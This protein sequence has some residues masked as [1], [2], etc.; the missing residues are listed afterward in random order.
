MVKNNIFDWLLTDVQPHIGL[1]QLKNTAQDY[2][3]QN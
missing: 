3:K 1:F 2:K